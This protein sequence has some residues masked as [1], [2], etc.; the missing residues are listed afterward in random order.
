MVEEECLKLSNEF[1]A[2]F[3]GINVLLN[4]YPNQFIISASYSHFMLKLSLRIN[5]NKQY[6]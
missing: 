3:F 2:F 1:Q 5:G 6:L 4:L